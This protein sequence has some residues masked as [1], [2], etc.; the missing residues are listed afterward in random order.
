MVRACNPPGAGGPLVAGGSVDGY[1]SAIDPPPARRP[2]MS[3]HRPLA[4]GLGLLGVLGLS[5]V[6]GQTGA[7]ARPERP[8]DAG[9]VAVRLRLG[10][11]DRQGQAWGGRVSLDVGEVIA[12]EGWRFRQG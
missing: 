11:A 3:A 6:W 7:A 4:L 1:V 12:V 5:A 9:T 8:L 2:G 10:I